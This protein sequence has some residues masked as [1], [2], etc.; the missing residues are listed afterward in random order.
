MDSVREKIEHAMQ[1]PKIHK[2]EIYGIIKEI[3]DIIKAPAPA[4]A[5]APAA[6]ATS[7]ATPAAA[8]IKAAGGAGGVSGSVV[9]VTPNNRGDGSPNPKR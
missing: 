1:R 2:N 5:P 4:P 3:V 7:T 9:S 8:T 6:V